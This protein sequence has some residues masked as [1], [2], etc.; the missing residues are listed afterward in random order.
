V[1]ESRRRSARVHPG[2]DVRHDAPVV[3]VRLCNIE[4]CKA[5]SSARGAGLWRVGGGGG[6]YCTT[7]RSSRSRRGPAAKPNPVGAFRLPRGKW[8]IPT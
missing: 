1:R 7:C 6:T 4:C 2:G 8:R 5:V 3:E